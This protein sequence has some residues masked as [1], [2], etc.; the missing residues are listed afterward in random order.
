MLGI[1]YLLTLAYTLKMP[2]VILLGLGSNSGTHSGYSPLSSVIR[3]AA[4]KPQVVVV[5]AIGNEAGRQRHFRGRIEAEAA[6]QDV[7]VR[8][9]EGQRAGRNGRH[10]RAARVLAALHFKK[11][12]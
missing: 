11:R 9:G 7:E 6:W 5:T 3:W 2:L 8:V 4:D 12:R 10:R 1:V